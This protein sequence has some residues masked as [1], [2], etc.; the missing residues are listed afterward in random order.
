MSH[1]AARGTQKKKI[2]EVERLKRRVGFRSGTVEK[3]SG[4]AQ[5][6]AKITD[7]PPVSEPK[8]S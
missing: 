3:L 5:W 6:R 4:E 2:D 8:N 7:L 1:W